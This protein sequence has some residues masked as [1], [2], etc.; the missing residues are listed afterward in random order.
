MS[1]SSIGSDSCA[2]L[3]SSSS[4]ASY[5]SGSISHISYLTE[6]ASIELPE[7]FLDSSQV[8]DKSL[9]YQEKEIAGIKELINREDVNRIKIYIN[10]TIYFTE[11]MVREISEYVKSIKKEISIFLHEMSSDNYNYL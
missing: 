8:L 1:K 3:S 11:E 5:S 4:M 2:S 9:P 10:E 6:T 7:E